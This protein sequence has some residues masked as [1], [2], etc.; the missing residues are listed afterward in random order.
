MMT[1]TYDPIVKNG[2]FQI[3]FGDTA[4][5]YRAINSED[6]RNKFAKFLKYD[7]T[8]AQF[9]KDC[10]TVQ[11]TPAVRKSGECVWVLK[12]YL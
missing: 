10:D 6:A 7:G 3:T 12:E 11:L 4:K 8:P 9:K 5:V 2:S 1:L